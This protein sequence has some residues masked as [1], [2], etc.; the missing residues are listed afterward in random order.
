MTTSP[1][2]YKGKG[3]SPGFFTIEDPGSIALVKLQHVS[4]YISCG[5][6]LRS[7]WACGCCYKTN[8]VLTL[9]TDSKDNPLFPDNV[10]ETRV[11]H[12]EIPLANFNHMSNELILPTSQGEQKVNAGDVWKIWFGEDYVNWAEFNNS[13]EH[14]VHISLFYA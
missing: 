4:G 2:C 9:I 8:T 7:Y 3:S 1:V 6:G 11:D 12:K 13:G 5:E 14:C 10:F